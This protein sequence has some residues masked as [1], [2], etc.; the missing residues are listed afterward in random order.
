MKD[1]TFENE[2]FCINVPKSKTDQVGNSQK[3]YLAHSSVYSVHRLLCDYI[4]ILHIDTDEFYLFPPLIWDKTSKRWVPK[5][6]ERLSYSSAARGFKNLMSHFGLQTKFLGLHSPRIGAT[7]DMFQNGVDDYIIDKRGRWKNPST[8][9]VYAK[10]SER[11]VINT[12]IDIANR[13]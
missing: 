1:L 12:V 7:T 8:K 2:V 9:Y 13:Y 5:R 10:D 4:R 6:N 3:I 11:H